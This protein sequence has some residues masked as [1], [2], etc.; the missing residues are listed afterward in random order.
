MN[1]SAVN[2]LLF[3]VFG[4]KQLNIWETYMGWK[5]PRPVKKYMKDRLADKHV[6]ILVLLFGCV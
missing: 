4:W 3:V 1:V 2:K 5:L 6:S